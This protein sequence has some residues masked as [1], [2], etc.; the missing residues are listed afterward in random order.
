MTC[1]VLGF[2]KHAYYQWRGPDTDGQHQVAGVPQG[3][4][5]VG[6]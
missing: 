6:G 2:S 5:R 1:R 4:V 3:G